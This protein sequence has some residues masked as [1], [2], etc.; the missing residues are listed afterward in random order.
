MLSCPYV[1]LFRMSNPFNIVVNTN[2]YSLKL[3]RNNELFKSYPIAV[4]AL[5][6][7]SPIGTFTIINKSINPGGPYGARWLG[8]NKK[9][10]G[11]HGTNNPNSIGKKVSHGC[12]R[13][14][15]R[16][17]IELSNIVSIGTI[18]KII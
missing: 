16:D 12:I 1:N 10:Y 13:M 8:L 14:Y 7:P 4:G 11:I 17:V 15:N 9:G 6:T 5:V 18:V 2:N 3:Y